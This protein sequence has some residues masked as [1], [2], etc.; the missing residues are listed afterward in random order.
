MFLSLFVSRYWFVRG[1]GL[2]WGY[3][4]EYLSMSVWVCP[5]RLGWGWLYLSLLK[6]WRLQC[7]LPPLSPLT[8]ELLQQQQREASRLAEFVR[9]PRSGGQ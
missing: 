1:L 3:R 7:G 2:A 6:R 9:Q 8:V 5:Y 4:L